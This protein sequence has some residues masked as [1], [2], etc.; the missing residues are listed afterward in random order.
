MNGKL[1]W[2]KRRRGIKERRR[3]RRSKYGKRR[4]GTMEQYKMVIF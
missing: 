4:R 3:R 2:R 1:I